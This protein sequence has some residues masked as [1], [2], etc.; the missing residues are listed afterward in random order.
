MN[1]RAGLGIAV[2][3]GLVVT[4][5]S[6]MTSSNKRGIASSETWVNAPA[7]ALSSSLISDLS[8]GGE[9][10]LKNA[11]L[12]VDN[13]RAFQSKLEM[14]R[15]ARSEIR[16]VYYIWS[17]DYTSSLLSTEVIAAARRGVKVKILVDFITNYERLDLF[18]YLES[19]GL[20]NIQVRFYGLPTATIQKGAVFQTLPCSK[21]PVK[22]PEQCQSEKLALMEKMGNPQTTWFSRMYLAGLYGKNV[23]LLKMAVGIGGQFDPQSLQAG[24]SE[25]TPEQKAKLK[26]FAKLVFKAKLQGDI[27][28]KIK[29]GIALSTYG[30]T[31]NPIMNELTGRLP[32]G[33][34][35]GPDWDHL[36]DYTHHKLLA[37]DGQKFQ[38]GGRNIEDSYHTDGLKKQI[39]DS[40][41]KYTFMDTDFYVESPDTKSVEEA[42]DRL[43]NFSAMVGGLKQVQALAP[44]EFDANATAFQMGLGLCLHSGMATPDDIE[45]CVNTKISSMKGYKSLSNRLEAVRANMAE[46]AFRASKEYKAKSDKSWKANGDQ[47]EASDLDSAE[48]YYIENLSFDKKSPN[49][50][51]FGS[52]IG[53]EAQH[54]KNLHALWAKGLENTCAVSAKSKQRTRVVL[55]TA[56]FLLSSNLTTA[57][58]NMINGKW[59][60]RNV[61]ILLL[62]N[63]FETTDLNVINIFARYQIRT[64]LAHNQYIEQNPGYVTANQNK[65]KI[66][67]YEYQPTKEGGGI[68][69]HTK[70][71]VLGND[72]IIGSANA[73]VRSYFMDTNNGVYLRNA[74]KLIRDYNGYINYLIATNQVKDLT[75]GFAGLSEQNLKDQNSQILMA[76]KARWDKNGKIDK[77][78]SAKILGALDRLGASISKATQAMITAPEATGGFGAEGANPSSDIS[79]ESLD[80]IANGFDQAWKIL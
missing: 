37:V 67:Y 50:R 65:A 39:K 69:L 63:S 10:E 35:G 74:P 22:S 48:A 32:L 9:L 64:L 68:S 72:I 56:Y 61:D 1:L 6:T 45:N 26:E 13:N 36:T 49:A 4:A 52:R 2:A 28:S 66:K 46:K 11:K 58:G 53:F 18:S 19:V 55:H 51:I 24:A 27:A 25:T 12:I 47:L 21:D 15:A 23:E 16:L 3:S 76:L 8:S 20:G 57:L 29:V 34:G 78:R 77:V 5:C 42:Y 60:C 17:D 73:D 7:K 44:N 80:E 33:L 54:G 38:L 75:Q 30:S 14:I 41:G 59:N 40:A 79:P 62:T 31:L 70:V 43:F 71:S